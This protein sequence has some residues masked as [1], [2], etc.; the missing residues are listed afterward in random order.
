MG[1]NCHLAERFRI[2]HFQGWDDG[3]IRAFYP[4]SGKSMFVINDCHHRGVSAIAIS[5]DCKRVISGGGEGM[6]SRAFL[7]NFVDIKNLFL[8]DVMVCLRSEYGLLRMIRKYWS[9]Q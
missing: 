2:F 1:A 4:E 8:N 5:S 6:V 7:L 9:T 3:K